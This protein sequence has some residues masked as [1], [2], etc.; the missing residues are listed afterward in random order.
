MNKVILIGRL[1]RDPE[2]HWTAN[3]AQVVT[4]RIATTETYTDRSGES[5]ERTEWHR[6][7]T[8]QKTAE[9]CVRYLTKGRLVYVEGKVQSRKWQDQQG[10]EREVTEVRAETVR[11]LDSPGDRKR[12]ARQAGDS[13]D[14][15]LPGEGYA[16]DIYWEPSESSMDD[17]PF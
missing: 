15:L 2:Q 10:Q 17:I 12:S 14:T 16:G 13:S 5:V 9:M 11:F 3:G 8:F 1:G 6:V 7:V 4:M